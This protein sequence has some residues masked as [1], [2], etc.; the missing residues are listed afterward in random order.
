MC[1]ML[2]DAPG[3]IEIEG[4]NVVVRSRSDGEPICQVWKLGD[5]EIMAANF[6]TQLAARNERPLNVVAFPGMALLPHAAETA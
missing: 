4:E 5:A 2:M 6:L 3:D 1:K